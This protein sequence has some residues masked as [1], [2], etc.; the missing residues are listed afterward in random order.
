MSRAEGEQKVQEPAGR[1]AE[2][3]RL[4]QRLFTEW[5]F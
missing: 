5:S 1:V 4:R 3:E 2:L